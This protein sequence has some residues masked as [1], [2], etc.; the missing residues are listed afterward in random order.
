MGSL[1]SIFKRLWLEFRRTGKVWMKPHNPNRVPIDVYLSFVSSLSGN[2]MTLFAGVIV[3][4]ATFLAVAAKVQSFLYIL[5]SAAVL[6]V[7]CTR[8]AI[9]RQFDRVDK[10][11]LSRAG[12]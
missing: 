1:K 5:L 2:R 12:I 4:V 7:F 11:T 6:L 10:E 8:M 3:H 9:F